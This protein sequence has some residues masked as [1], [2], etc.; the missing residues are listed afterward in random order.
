MLSPIWDE[1]ADKAKTEFTI[2]GQVYIGKIDCDK[3]GEISRQKSFTE[4]CH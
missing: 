2:P 1:F 3:E 4:W